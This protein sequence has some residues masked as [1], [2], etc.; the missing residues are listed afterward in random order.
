MEKNDIKTIK[1]NLKKQ[2]G[3]NSILDFFLIYKIFFDPKIEIDIFKSFIFSEFVLN[4]LNLITN[5]WKEELKKL[6]TEIEKDKESKSKKILYLN[7]L[8]WIIE[9]ESILDPR[10]IYIENEFLNKLLYTSKFVQTPF[11]FIYKSTIED[12][13]KEDSQLKNK[14]KNKYK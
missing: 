3:N 5:N 2:S 8:T 11:I 1:N 14:K 9:K 7:I 6:F 13:Q 12:Y 4:L 10:E